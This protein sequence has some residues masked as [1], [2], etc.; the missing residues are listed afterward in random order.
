MNYN[1]RLAADL[2]SLVANAVNTNT[3]EEALEYLKENYSSSPLVEHTT[4]VL[5]T[6]QNK[7]L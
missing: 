3:I 7:K 4:N 2:I 6:I 1:N 5:I